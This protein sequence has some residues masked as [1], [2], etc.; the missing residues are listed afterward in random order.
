MKVLYIA[1]FL[2]E[3]DSGAKSVARTHLDVLIKGY[4]INNV[5]TIALVGTRT[6]IIP[7][8]DKNFWIERINPNPI[9]RGINLLGGYTGKINNRIVVKMSDFIDREGIDL[10]F[11]DDSIYGKAIKRIKRKYPNVI[12]AS[13]YHD[14]KRNLCVDWIKKDKK[15]TMIY[16]SLIYNEFLTQKYADYNLVLN[17]REEREY[18][19][20]YNKN[21]EVIFPV[22]LPSPDLFEVNEKRGDKVNILFVGGYYYPNVNGIDWFVNNVFHKL[23]GKYSLT[24]IG[25]KMNLIADKYDSI[26]NITVHGRIEDLSPYY[27]TA[28]LIIGPIFEGAGMKVKTAEALSYG[29][30]FVGTDESLEGYAELMDNTI[31]NKYVI[32]CNNADQFKAAIEKIYTNKIVINKFN[33]EVRYFFEKHYSITAAAET[34]VRS[35]VR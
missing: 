35:L 33:H 34:L 8:L 12:I 17:K 26:P 28:D 11:F 14:V 2:F 22:V 10:V 29:K 13:Y 32:I 31:K 3:E 7:L 6:E 16:L 4:G 21:P 23:E 25:N 27:Q 19:K 30:C 15:K 9:Y 1:N 5:Y 20:Y 18:K 24:I